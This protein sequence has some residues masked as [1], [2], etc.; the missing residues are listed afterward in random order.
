MHPS[1]PKQAVG[2]PQLKKSTLDPTASYSY[3]PLSNLPLISKVVEHVVTR[4][5]ILFSSYALNRSLSHAKQSAQ[6]SLSIRIYSTETTL[7]SVHDDLTR[8]ID[9]A[10]EVCSLVL[11][12]FGSAFDTVES[13]HCPF[14]SIW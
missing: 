9:R 10:G 11:R 1:S 2:V 12:D 14:R 5:F 7:L 4:R 3:R 6:T 13:Y 8:A